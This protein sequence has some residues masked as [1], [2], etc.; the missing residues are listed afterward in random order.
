MQQPSSSPTSKVISKCEWFGC[1]NWWGREPTQLPKP[2]DEDV[3]ITD[4]PTPAVVTTSSPT[5]SGI[6]GD[7]DVPVTDAPTPVPTNTVR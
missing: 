6:P 1:L 3:P 4:A 5:T 2:G 7:E